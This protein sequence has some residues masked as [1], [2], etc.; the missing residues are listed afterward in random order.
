MRRVG[1]VSRHGGGGLRPVEGDGGKTFDEPEPHHFARANAEIFNTD[2]NGGIPQIVNT[3]LLFS[4]PGQIDLLPALPKEWPTGK[5]TGLRARGGFTVDIEW[6][7]GKVTNYR[8][9][10]PES[11]E[12]KI[13]VKTGKSRLYIVRRSRDFSIP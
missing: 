2:G 5:V 8:V 13:L 11:K 7:D 1:G 9:T 3:M 12:V 10:S 6:K 4:R